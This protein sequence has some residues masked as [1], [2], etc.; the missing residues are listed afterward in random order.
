MEVIAIS[1]LP[2]RQHQHLRG[3]TTI[4]FSAVDGISPLVC[5]RPVDVDSS[6]RKLHVVSP[7]VNVHFTP[8]FRTSNDTITLSGDLLSTHAIPCWQLKG[9]N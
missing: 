1:I 5:R 7:E 6:S 3:Q 8:F 9:I 2:V 4:A